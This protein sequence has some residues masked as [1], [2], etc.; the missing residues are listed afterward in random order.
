[1]VHERSGHAFASSEPGMP[2]AN[3]INP[4]DTWDNLTEQALKC[5]SLRFLQ[6]GVSFVPSGRFGQRFAFDHGDYDA[7]VD[8]ER[9]HRAACCKTQGD[10]DE[11][12]HGAPLSRA[13]V[14]STLFPDGLYCL[15]YGTMVSNAAISS[16]PLK[17]CIGSH[18][19]L[20]TYDGA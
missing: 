19:L 15:L 14:P 2:D 10:V 3:N 16:I 4:C 12:L 18:A 13:H 11:V 6:E 7:A 8:D 9:G 20:P 1:M 5:L 17:P